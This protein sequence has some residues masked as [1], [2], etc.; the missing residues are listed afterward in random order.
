MNRLEHLYTIL[1]EEGVEV[2]QRCSKLLRFG[3][4][5]IQP[6]QDLTN[7]ERL[8]GEVVD[9]LAMVRM[10]ADEGLIEPISDAD[11][12]AME[13]KRQKVEKFLKYSR[14]QGTLT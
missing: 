7:T 8:R 3:A 10:L 9:L 14:L 4:G 6:G 2:A 13:A 1:G 12:P 11:L 5:E